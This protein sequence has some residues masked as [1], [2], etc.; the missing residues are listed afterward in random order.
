MRPKVSPDMIPAKRTK[1]QEIPAYT[2]HQTEPN[3]MPSDEGPPPFIIVDVSIR[4][5]TTAFSNCIVVW[6]SLSCLSSL[7]QLNDDD[8]LSLSLSLYSFLLN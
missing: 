6:I 1:T 7:I 3:G 5:A 8:K 2:N 4:V